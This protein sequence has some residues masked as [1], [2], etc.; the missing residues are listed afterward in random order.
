MLSEGPPPS[1]HALSLTQILLLEELVGLSRFELLTPRLSS[2]CSNQLS[3]RPQAIR[4]PSRGLLLEPRFKEPTSPSVPPTRAGTTA[5]NPASRRCG[6]SAPPA[7]CGRR[8]ILS[9]L[10]RTRVHDLSTYQIDL[11]KL[12]VRPTAR[13]KRRVDG[14][15]AGTLER[16]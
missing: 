4:E 9:K 6:L 2:V 14:T 15:S 3:Y 7:Q 8:R 13:R 12:R 16:R 10:D 5:G 11:F 1:H